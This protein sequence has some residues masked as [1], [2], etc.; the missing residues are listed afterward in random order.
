MLLEDLCLLNK[1]HNITLSFPFS[2]LIYPS[3]SSC[4][5]C[6]FQCICDRSKSLCILWDKA[7]SFMYNN[8]TTNVYV[9][10]SVHI[11]LFQHY[12][13]KW[14]EICLNSCYEA[15]GK[16]YWH[17]RVNL[18]ILA[19]H[20]RRFFEH[21]TFYSNNWDLNMIDLQQFKMSA[22]LFEIFINQ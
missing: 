13:I 15:G 18:T 10:D 9:N 3:S 21:L 5:F 12:I 14:I 6:C 20:L 7:A 22:Q 11:G 16:T 19:Y 1:H 4:V 8:C 17:L 2:H